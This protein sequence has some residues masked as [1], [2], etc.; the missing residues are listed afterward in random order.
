MAISKEFVQHIINETIDEQPKVIGISPV[1]GGCI[2]NAQKVTTVKGNFFIKMNQASDLNMFKT[3]YSG[4][5]LLAS[6]GEINVPESIACGVRDGQAYLLLNFIDSS[7]RKSS[8]WNDFGLALANLHKNHCNDR[9]GLSYNNYIGRLDQFNEFSE[10]WISFFIEQRLEA[11]LKLAFDNGYIDRT[12]LTNCTRFYQKLPELLPVEPPSLLHGD[13]WS[14][15]FMTGEEGQPVIIDPAVYYGHR[16]IELSFTQMFGGFDRQFYRSYMEAYPLQPGF[17][18]RVEIY[19]M[20]P[21]LVHVNLFGPSY[22]GGVT[23]VIR[24]Y[25]K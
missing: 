8:F 5:E 18:S 24:R 4:L 15:N 13:L 17:E 1:S 25:A 11:Q 9:Y 14:G 21:H 7:A 10:D 19:N 3:E 12:Y 6:A 22:L 20:Y 16:E 2:H 23:P